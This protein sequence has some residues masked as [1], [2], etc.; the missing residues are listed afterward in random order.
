[1]IIY[2]KER[3]NKDEIKLNK[4][5]RTVEF[6]NGE[7]LVSVSIAIYTEQDEKFIINK[8]NDYKRIFKSDL[9]IKPNFSAFSA[10]QTFQ[11]RMVHI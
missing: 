1:M 10:V 5:D 8:Y 6:K 9:I 2:T 7:Y 3:G 11:K 4:K